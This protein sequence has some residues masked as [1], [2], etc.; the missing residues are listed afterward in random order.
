MHRAFLGCLARQWHAQLCI[1]NANFIKA[2]L[3]P[4]SARGL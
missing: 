2:L 4:R 1:S 3:R